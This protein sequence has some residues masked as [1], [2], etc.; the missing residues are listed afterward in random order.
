MRRTL[1]LMLLAAT[2]LAAEGMWPFN[3]VP[4]RQL[5]KEH[6][7]TPDAAWLAHARL[8]SVRFNN[9]GSGSFVSGDGLVMTNHHVGSDCIQKLSQ[10]KTDYMKE[11]FYAA[12][13]AEEQKCPDLELNVLEGIEDVTDKVKGA[14]QGPDDAARNKAG[15]AEMSRLEKQCHEE[16]KLRCDV[17]TLYEGGAYHLYRYRKHTDVRLVFAPEFQAAFFGGDQDNFTYPRMNLD[18]AF[19]RIYG[20]DDKPVPTPKHLRFSDTGAQDGQ[21]VF[22]SGNPGRTGRFNTP[23]YLRFLRDTAYPWILDRLQAH[24]AALKAYMDQG[25]AQYKAARDDF[26]GTENGIKAITGYLGGLRDAA[27]LAEVERRHEDVKKKVAGHPDLLQA[28]PKLAAAYDEYAKFYK[29]LAVTERWLS[30]G[31]QLMGIARHLLRYS[32]EK[33]KPDAERLREYASAG[34]D[35]LKLQLFSEAP[36][37]Q[38]LQIELVAHGLGNLVAVLGAEHEVVKAALGG[39]TPRARAEEAVKGSKLADVAFRKQLFEGGKAAVDA[40]KD[41]LIELARSYDGLARELRKRHE[42]NVESVEK[43]WAGKIAEAWAAAY[44]QSVYPDA[45][46]TLRLNHGVV[47]GYADVPWRT[48]FADLY[49]K[50]DE[51]KGK[52]PYDLPRRWLDA[53]KKLDLQVPYNF[54]STND[55]IGG[56]SGSPVFDKELRAVGLIFDGNIE[57]LPNR[58]LYRSDKERSV[59]VHTAGILHALEVVYGAAG[60]LGELKTGRVQ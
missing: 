47:K 2:T 26:F 48:T 11:G 41:P 14:M 39:K 29:E 6:G 30:P 46:F 45:T 28:W 7:F 34:I 43:Q 58:F 40:A 1:A 36:V 20:E 21:L 5:E 49:R 57:Q 3:M 60:L 55:I 53:R 12:T 59:S 22:V 15:K 56:N 42:D 32:V 10:G 50:Y 24:R 38:G 54:V 17:V 33:E 19:F 4:V 23:A 8:A 18:A 9:G 13:R 35:S 44:G 31:G 25:E 16:T 37:D 27:L 51:A 52:A